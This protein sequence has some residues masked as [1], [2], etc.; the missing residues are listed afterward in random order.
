M[1]AH[2]PPRLNAAGAKRLRILPKRV[3]TAPWAQKAIGIAACNYL[4]LVWNTSRFIFEPADLYDRVRPDLPVIVAVWHGQHFMTSF[5]KRDEHR[6]KV[7]ISRHRDGEINAVVAERLGAETIR[8]SGDH[9]QEFLRKGGVGA[10]RSMVSALGD[11][12]NI[13]MTADVPK[14]SRIAGLGIVMLARASGRPIYPVAMATSRRRLMLRSWDKSA[15]NLPFSRGA[16]VMGEPIRV[17]AEAGDDD[18]E[19]AR[20]RVETQLN[21]VT[22]RAYALVDRRPGHADRA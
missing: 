17:A 14:V 11:G 15:V 9:N 4:R 2:G 16:V 22:D 13:V 19:T 21:L 5:L 6:V 10:F 12:Y 18:L 20:R 7:L 8:G 1:A 3:T